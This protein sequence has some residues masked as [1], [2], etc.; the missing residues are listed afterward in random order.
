MKRY[1]TC[2]IAALLVVITAQAAGPVGD[3]HVA[4][5]ATDMEVI[6]DIAC[7][8]GE[9]ESA[10]S[11]DEDIRPPITFE[12]RIA[13]WCRG[14]MRAIGSIPRTQSAIMSFD[15]ILSSLRSLKTEYGSTIDRADA[16]DTDLVTLVR[17]VSGIVDDLM[18][19]LG[20]YGTHISP[21][22]E[23]PSEVLQEDIEQVNETIKLLKSEFGKL[24]R[25]L[26]L[27]GAAEVILT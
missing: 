3:Q 6:L 19:H 15:A 26:N 23:S 2:A 1:F 17:A 9:S 16:T 20:I 18:G 10:E 22:C 25:K 13:G 12:F 27:L 24:A 21:R 14:L 11:S 5:D 8:S 4:M 7:S